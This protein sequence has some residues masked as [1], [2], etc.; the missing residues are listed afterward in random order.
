MS[1]KPEYVKTNEAIKRLGVCSD[2]LR[3]WAETGKIEFI[4]I[5]SGARR[6]NVDKYVEVNR[7]SKTLL[8]SQPK[9]SAQT[10]IS[11]TYCRV[12]SAHQKDDLG[13]QVAHMR[14]KYPTHTLVTDIGSGLNFK[15]KGLWSIVER[16]MQGGV[17]EV[18]VAHVDRLARFAHEF[19]QRL[20][21]LNR[22]RLVVEDRTEHA[23]DE[24]ELAEDLLSIVHVFSRRHNGKRRYHQMGPARQEKGDEKHAEEG[25]EQKRVHESSTDGTSESDHSLANPSEQ[26][27]HAGSQDQ[28]HV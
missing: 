2:T 8:P 20:F 11:F 17:D 27:V 9:E 15:R 3:S 7:T 22:T 18:V 23:S 28:S 13:R 24:Q 10:R 21:E 14:S 12:S 5:A 16:V 19:I 6:Y 25:R 4:R 1:K 26:V